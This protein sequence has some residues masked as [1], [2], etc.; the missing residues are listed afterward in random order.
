MTEKQWTEKRQ[1][2]TLITDNVFCNRSKIFA[3]RVDSDITKCYLLLLGTDFLFSNLRVQ[4]THLLYA[5]C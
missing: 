5:H 4:P 3:V 2:A 1:I